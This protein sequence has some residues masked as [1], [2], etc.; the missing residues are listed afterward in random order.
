MSRSILHG[1]M[2]G[3]TDIKGAL[4]HRQSRNVVQAAEVK[5]ALGRISATGAT[6]NKIEAYSAGYG[7]Y[8]N[9]QL[10]STLDVDI[11][12]IYASNRY[13]P[14]NPFQQNALF[15]QIYRYDATAGT[16][17]ELYLN[18]MWGPFSLSGITDRTILHAYEDSF[19]NMGM[20]RR[21][22]DL[23]HDYFVLGKFCTHH[24]FDEKKGVWA[25]MIQHNPDFIRV[26]PIPIVDAEPILHLVPPPELRSLAQRLLGTKGFKMDKE[27]T[28]I[29]AVIAA[30]NQVQLNSENTFYVPRKAGAADYYGTSIYSRILHLVLIESALMNA[31]LINAYRRAGPIRVVSPQNTDQTLYTPEQLDALALMFMEADEDPAGSTIVL[32][33]PVTIE[34]LGSTNSE[35]WRAFDDWDVIQTGKLHALGFSETLISGEASYST[36][37]IN[38]SVFLKRIEGI[39]QTITNEYLI[40]KVC[41]TLAI[42]MDFKKTSKACLDHRIRI[43]GGEQEYILPHINYHQNLSP[44]G[45]PQFIEAL[46]KAEEKGVPV[47]LTRWATA[48]GVD[49]NQE[50]TSMPEDFRM[51]AE[52]AKYKS[53]P[54]AEGDLDASIVTDF[55][56][57][58]E[59]KDLGYNQDLKDGS[60]SK[61]GGVLTP[62]NYRLLTPDE[63]M[64]AAGAFKNQTMEKLPSHIYIAFQLFLKAR[65]LPYKELT[66]SEYD[67]LEVEISKI[68]EEAPELAAYLLKE[69]KGMSSEVL[70]EQAED[71]KAETQLVLKDDQVEHQNED[72]SKDADGVVVE[73]TDAVGDNQTQRL[74]RQMETRSDKELDPIELSK[75]GIDEVNQE[76]EMTV[77]M[78]EILDR[79]NKSEVKD[80]KPEDLKELGIDVDEAESDVVLQKMEDAASEIENRELMNEADP[81]DRKVDAEVE[82]LTSKPVKLKDDVSQRIFDK[83]VHLLRVQIFQR[84]LLLHK[85]AKVRKAIE[86]SDQVD[87]MR[88]L[89]QEERGHI[90]KVGKLRDSI[91]DRKS[92]LIKVKMLSERIHQEKIK[93][94]AETLKLNVKTSELRHQ[95]QVMDT[96]KAVTDN[97]WARPAERPKQPKSNPYWRDEIPLSRHSDAS[98]Q[99]YEIEVKR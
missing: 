61:F 22:P 27:M 93:R 73:Q 58:A 36:T 94:L 12:N 47:S 18:M 21:L 77:K 64:R 96:K 10:P 20:E 71:K 51:R 6:K 45:D 76:S 8:T 90:D 55:K 29:M 41:K 35:Q 63:M 95:V 4:A 48:C 52:I 68:E 42:A 11:N 60:L 53:D 24:I 98:Q 13:L 14:K 75:T 1:S 25:K 83:A 92:D 38:L 88:S 74:R 5:R 85:V 50:M 54:T 28:T 69:M 66:E 39:R 70:E 9:I 46:E 56:N 17:I 34:T 3:A 62:Y 32:K 84:K 72:V 65:K 30:Q 2:Q 59:F 91:R 79:L 89:I 33:E 26:T 31:N 67:K 78:A 49:I 7:N 44:V 86:H 23:A 80:F 15:R 57:I 40:N 19:D 16:A 37:E 82:E 97:T 81:E 87:T 43:K 99:P